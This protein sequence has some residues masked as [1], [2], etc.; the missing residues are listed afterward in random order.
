MG[1]LISNYYIIFLTFC[2]LVGCFGFSAGI[3]K[4]TGQKKLITGTRRYAPP[5]AGMRVL[6][7]VVIT[8]RN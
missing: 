1:N 3:T 8:V 7:P 2:R 5:R 6:H 4:K